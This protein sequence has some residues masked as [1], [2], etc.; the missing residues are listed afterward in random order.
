MTWYFFKTLREK[1]SILKKLKH[2]DIF[3]LLKY[4]AYRLRLSQFFHLT[5]KWYTMR[6][7]YSPY[8]FWLWTHEEKEK[9][10]EVFLESFLKA[11]DTFIDCGAHIGTLTITASKLVGDK[12]KVYSY[13]AHPRT[14]TYLERNVK[15]NHCSNVILKNIAIGGS[16]GI[17]TFSDYY[18]SD[19]NA[20]EKGGRHAVAMTTLDEDLTE[21]AVINLLKLDIEGCELPALTGATETLGRTQVIYFESAT[22]SFSRFGYSL[23]D[24]VRTLKE[25]GFDC[26]RMS[27]ADILQKIDSDY[28][29][30]VRYENIL[31]ARSSFLDSDWYKK[32]L[33]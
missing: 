22:T 27:G 24:M 20:V 11:G 25:S 2:G 9:D 23:Q 7:F 6:V 12:G 30:K 19:L 16:S 3:P 1:Q 17:V 31:A 5:R 32:H 33:K 13:E 15:E 8:A 28:E 18:A 14:F 29:T 26:Y 21:V 4:V 10:E